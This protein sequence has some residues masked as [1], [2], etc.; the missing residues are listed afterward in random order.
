MYFYSTVVRKLK[1]KD[2]MWLSEVFHLE[3]SRT[4]LG[5]YKY[6]WHGSQAIRKD[7][8]GQG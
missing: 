1:S 6:L 5:V 8:P 4:E 2:V 3:S 7:L